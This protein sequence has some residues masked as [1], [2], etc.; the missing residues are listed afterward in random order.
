MP[1]VREWRERLR[2]ERD[3]REKESEGCDDLVDWH[4]REIDVSAYRAEC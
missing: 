3:R 2:K 4:E 1:E